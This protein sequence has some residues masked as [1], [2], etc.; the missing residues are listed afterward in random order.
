V[1]RFSG[2]QIAACCE[3]VSS[4]GAVRPISNQFPYYLL[5]RGIET[6]TLATCRSL[7]VGI[8]GY[9]PLAQGVLT[10]KYL[11]GQCPRGSR[12]DHVAKKDMWQHTEQNEPIVARLR[13]VAARHG[14]EL[15]TLALAW[16]LVRPGISAVLTGATSVEQVRA[17][18][19]A[20]ELE[21]SEELLAEV[22]EA[23]APE[24]CKHAATTN[25]PVVVNLENRRSIIPCH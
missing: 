22:E 15:S 6:E 12:S 11:D 18:A 20:A 4:M 2:E 16:C 25:H 3:L 14:L 8:I 13:G 23:L 24:A 1:S 5:E 9:S 17:N 21:L 10:G 19:R 7:G